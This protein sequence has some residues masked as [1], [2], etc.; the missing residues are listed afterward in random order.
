MRGRLPI[1]LLFL[2]LACEP[3]PDRDPVV[4]AHPPPDAP[5]T[6]PTQLCRTGAPDITPCR[7]AIAVE[8]LLARPD[9]EIL[10]AAATPAGI[11]GARVLT[12][13]AAGIPPVVFRAKWRALSTATRRNSPRREL[14][15]YAVQ[16]VFL[17]PGDYVAPPTAAHCFP[18]A[19]YR[20]RVDPRARASVPHTACV[21]GVLSYWLEDVQ[22][23]RSA[24]RAGWFHGGGH[25]LDRALFRSS[26]AYRD[27][28]AAVNLFTYV[29][30]HADSHAGNFVITLDPDA[31][32]VYSVDNSLSL[33]LPHNRRIPP[34]H[35]WSRL[36]VPALHAGA[37]DR[38][39][40]AGRALDRLGAIA[41]LE[42]RDGVLAAADAGRAPPTR[43]G[44]DWWDGQ[45][46]IGLTPHEI[47]GI[48]AR[49]DA[50][51]R[52]LDRHQIRL[53]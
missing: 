35:D 48:R 41:V 33:G 32:L 12:L 45:L 18:L 47:A 36:Q 38:L 16:K 2:Q 53:Y 6:P 21:L 14:A 24:A 28:V 37:I 8:A 29:I 46:V 9:L 15:A 30:G 40:R 26:D 42:K 49:I 27:S 10:G 1:L 34:R 22:S 51:L 17:D 43:T 7:D 25:A 44:M 20:A 31:P 39:R 5:L 19:D 23:L 3:E 50:L 52:R 4:G 13:R 11:Q